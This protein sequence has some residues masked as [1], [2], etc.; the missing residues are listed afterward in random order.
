MSIENTGKV[1][2]GSYSVGARTAGAG[3]EG[4]KDEMPKAT[5]ESEV[6]GL[7]IDPEA[8]FDTL[9]VQGEYNRANIVRTEK[10]EINPSDYLSDER[11]ADIEAMMD[12]FDNGVKV[13]AESIK[14]EFPSLS[15]DTAY[16]LAANIYAAG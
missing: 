14:A 1:M 13:M 2:F 12:E 5:G 10:K 11:I 3:K 4:I 9:N 7:E 8:V 6:K 16:A 15:D